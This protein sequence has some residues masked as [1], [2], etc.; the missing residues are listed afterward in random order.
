M[1]ENDNREDYVRRLPSR[2]APR[3]LP[4]VVPFPVQDSSMLGILARADA[5]I[6]AP[7]AR[8]R[9]GG[10]TGG[11]RSVRLDGVM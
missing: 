7:R 3:A 1:G 11:A 9:G 10:G 2:P 6:G 8:A 5:L 4:E